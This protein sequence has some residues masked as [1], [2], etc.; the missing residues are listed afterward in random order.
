M[1]S[2]KAKT[3]ELFSGNEVDQNHGQRTDLQ[4]ERGDEHAPDGPAGAQ[5]QSGQRFLVLVTS[6]RRRL[7]DEDN[8]CEKFHVDC[9][10]H[11]GLL[12]DDSAKTTRIETRQ[13]IVKDD[14]D[15]RT[16]IEII[17]RWASDEEEH[18]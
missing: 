15:L 8:L 17:D 18:K 16:E 10:R 2:A 1:K 3:L 7:L 13:V 6:F 4:L 9:C 12:P 14:E 5:G 11:A